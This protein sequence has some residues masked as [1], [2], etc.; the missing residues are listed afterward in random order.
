MAIK[1]NGIEVKKIIHN[2]TEVSKVIV[3]DTTVFDAGGGANRRLVHG[4]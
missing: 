4:C 1:V 3:D 2:S